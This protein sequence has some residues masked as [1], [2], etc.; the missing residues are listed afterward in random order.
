MKKKIWSVIFIFSLILINIS[1]F[2]IGDDLDDLEQTVREMRRQTKYKSQQ[3]I[4]SQTKYQ[5]PQQ[6]IRPL[7]KEIT[8]PEPIEKDRAATRNI[9]RLKEM[10]D[11]SKKRPIQNFSDWSYKIPK[12]YR[13]II[14]LL[15]VAFFIISFSILVY[16]RKL[17][18]QEEKKFRERHKH[19]SSKD[20]PLYKY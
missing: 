8:P 7:T 1:I 15:A 12:E 18:R 13:S 4:D 3:D 5:L 11:A 17:K 6:N 19:D 10:M 9:E 16:R 2:C 14:E 20:L